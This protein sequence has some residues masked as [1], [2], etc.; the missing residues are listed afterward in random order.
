MLDELA[1]LG[2]LGVLGDLADPQVV[3]GEDL[4]A[5]LLLHLMMLHGRAPSDDR[6]LVAPSRQRQDPTFADQ[7]L[8]A[9]VVDETVDLLQLGPQHLGVGQV[10]VPSL[11]PGPD[12]EDHGKH[13]LLPKGRGLAV[14]G[15]RASAGPA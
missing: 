10:F 5:T 12:F 14:A 7:A 15:V 6:L 11:F 1:A 9:D 2:D 3:V 13:R 8:V 4:A